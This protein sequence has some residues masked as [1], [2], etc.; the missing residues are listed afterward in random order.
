M[1]PGELRSKFST[2]ALEQIRENVR[3]TIM[4]YRSSWDLYT[5]LIQNAVDAIIDRFGYENISDGKIK[6]TFHTKEREIYIEDNG[7][8]IKPTDISSILVMGESL[9]RKEGRGKYGFM[10]YG[11]TFVSFQTEF[12]RIESVFNGK[13]ASRTYIDLYKFVFEGNELPLSEEEKNGQEEEDT[14]EESG[15]KITL[16]FPSEFPSETLEKNIDSAFYHVTSNEM[17]EYIL[18]TKSA[19]GIVDS[20]FNENMNLFSI[21]VEVN[22]KVVPIETGH[23]TTREMVKKMY[24]AGNFYDI[25]AYDSFIDVTKHLD[26][27]ARKVARKAMLI[28]GKYTNV[29]VGVIN[30]LSVNIYIAETSKAH[31]GTYNDKF[32][33]NDRYEKLLVKNGIWLSIDGLPTGI[34][35]DPLSHGSYLPFTVIVDVIDENKEVKNELDSG[36][37]G[38][39]EYR[40][41]QIVTVVKKLLKDKNFIDYRE[42]VLG[43]DTRVNTDGYD[44]K[45]ELRNKLANKQHFDI[46]LVHQYFPVENEQ[47]VITLFTELIS[48]GLLPGYYPKVIS[49]FDVYDGLYDYKTDFPNEILLPQDSLGISESVKNRQASMDREI[50]IEYKNYLRGIFRDLKEVKK[51]LQDIDILVCWSV[52]YEKVND[53]VESDG[54][55]LK[56]VDQSENF[57]YG[58]T[59]EV[60]G[61][62]RN[63][64]FLPIIELKTILNKKFGTNL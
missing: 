5:E 55:V 17:L 42:Y 49:G 12:L 64:N 33:N 9:K 2:L 26:Q 3:R 60:A 43:V 54:I 35:L 14:Q 18:R 25:D 10:G 57:Y 22:D 24:P 48:R 1:N 7:I 28:D 8:G 32:P 51:R 6:L 56:E 21:D 44:A 63:T 58:V 62:G 47:E 11:F 39:T 30:P 37:K 15:T 20:V 31:L 36:R 53:F 45:R 38:I 52:E 46:D 59:H 34:C 29:R 13:K 41:S 23:L 61:L 19:V 40:A 50:V 4:S 27:S 16:R